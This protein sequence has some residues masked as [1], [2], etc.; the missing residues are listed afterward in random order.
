MSRFESLSFQEIKVLWEV[1][2]Y[3][4][5]PTSSRYREKNIYI[6]ALSIISI[7]L[8]ASLQQISARSLVQYTYAT[9]M[10]S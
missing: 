9:I 2:V 10:L 3:D 5:K 4:N 6:R 8:I 1:F 7:I